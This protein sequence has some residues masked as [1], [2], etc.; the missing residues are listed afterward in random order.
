LNQEVLVALSCSVSAISE[1]ARSLL[2][3]S[4]SSVR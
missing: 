4:A 2:A 3:E 1:F